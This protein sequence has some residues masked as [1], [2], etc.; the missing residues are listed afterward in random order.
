MFRTTRSGLVRLSPNTDFTWNDGRSTAAMGF[1]WLVWL[2]ILFPGSID[3]AEVTFWYNNAAATGYPPS[4]SFGEPGA[5]QYPP[6][7]VCPQEPHKSGALFFR[8]SHV[9]TTLGQFIYDDGLGNHVV[10][11]AEMVNL[12]YQGSH[13]REDG[14]LVARDGEAQFYPED[15]VL[16]PSLNYNCHAQA[17]GYNSLWAGMIKDSPALSSTYVAALPTQSPRSGI[18]QMSGG[19][20]RRV[21]EVCWDCPG[22]RIVTVLEKKGSSGVYQVSSEGGCRPVD[23]DA[24]MYVYCPPF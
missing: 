2:S 19:H 15:Y 23:A 21:I 1:A 6:L 20:S 10:V 22:W 18:E 4:Q 17:M 13:V 11:T 14:T 9:T 3:A 24:T 7:P 8:H 5:P 12:F 16:P